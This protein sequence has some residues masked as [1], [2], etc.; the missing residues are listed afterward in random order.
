MAPSRRAT[1]CNEDAAAIDV[2]GA[3]WIGSRVIFAVEG[4]DTVAGT[5]RSKVVSAA[6][7]SSSG[8]R[9]LGELGPG[10]D[11]LD[12]VTGSDVGPIVTA[13]RRPAE[14]PFGGLRV[15]TLR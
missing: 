15:S 2:A 9:V 11:T 3:G 13:E 8:Q 14:G 1:A 4:I 10:P 12:Y 5:F 7:A 6:S